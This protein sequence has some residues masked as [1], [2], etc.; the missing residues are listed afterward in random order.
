MNITDFLGFLAAFCTTVSFIP[1]AIMVHKTKNTQSLSLTMYCI[2]VFGIG[3]WFV[4]GLLKNDL[5][6]IVANIITLVLATSILIQIIRNKL[7]HSAPN[8]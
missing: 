5:P 6:M 3:M 8:N 2:F 4:Y 1:Q 7:K